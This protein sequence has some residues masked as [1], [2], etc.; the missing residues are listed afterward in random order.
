MTGSETK[1]CRPLHNYADK[2]DEVP[3]DEVPQDDGIQFI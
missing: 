3:Q 1:M 2:Q